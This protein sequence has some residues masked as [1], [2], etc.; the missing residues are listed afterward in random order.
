MTTKPQSG[1]DHHLNDDKELFK[2]MLSEDPSL[3]PPASSGATA[4]PA[5]KAPALDPFGDPSNLRLPPDQELLGIKKIL[6]HIHVGKP[7]PQKFFRVHSDD[8]NYSMRVG[9]ITLKDGIEKEHYLVHAHLVSSL[10][11]EVRPHQIFLTITYQGSLGL[12]PIALPTSGR[13]NAWTDTALIGASTAK[14]EWT[15]LVP[16]DGCYEIFIAQ[17]QSLAEPSWPADLQPM[18]ELLRLGFKDRFIQDPD[19]EVLQ[20]L[21]GRVL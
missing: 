17:N 20:R 18:T 21:A 14:T 5:T 12:W 3:I 4:P 9:L 16:G 13:S 8:I 1:P 11:F 15:R 2:E 19:H 7:H 10:S 6:A